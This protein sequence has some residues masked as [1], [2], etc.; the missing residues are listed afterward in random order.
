MP[1]SPHQSHEWWFLKALLLF[2]L[3][4]YD[5]R[6]LWNSSESVY[7]R[8]IDPII[9]IYHHISFWT[10]QI[11]EHLEWCLAHSHPQYVTV[12]WRSGWIQPHPPILLTRSSKWLWLIQ[13]L[14]ITSTRWQFAIFEIF[15]QR[16][17]MFLRKH[18]ILLFIEQMFISCLLWA[19]NI[20][21]LG[22]QWWTRQ[23]YSWLSARGDRK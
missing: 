2:Q 20:P 5:V 19:G 16:N 18:F 1:E 14:K 15:F 22:L 7:Y 11:I 13:K 6:H 12:E 10:N 8:I 21:G 4:C 23:M 9:L 17:L 3:C